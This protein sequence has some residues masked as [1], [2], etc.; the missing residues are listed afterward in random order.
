MVAAVGPAGVMLTR[1]TARSGAA[2]GAIPATDTCARWLLLSCQLL[3]ATR[4]MLASSL[5]LVTVYCHWFQTRRA[6]TQLPLASPSTRRPAAGA[7]PAV[8]DD[9]LRGTTISA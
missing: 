1:E 6:L 2:V 9:L 3:A 8:P 7:A 4:G 5:T